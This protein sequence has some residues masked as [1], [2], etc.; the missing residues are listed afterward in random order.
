MWIA[1]YLGVAAVLPLTALSNNDKA[2][3]GSNGSNGDSNLV[4]MRWQPTWLINSVG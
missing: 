4:T 3:N 2:A 1:K